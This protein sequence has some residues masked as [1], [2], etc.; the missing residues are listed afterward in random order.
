MTSYAV[1]DAG[2]LLDSSNSILPVDTQ[3]QESAPNQVEGMETDQPQHEP[4]LA[5][6]Q[7][8]AVEAVQSEA[9]LALLNENGLQPMQL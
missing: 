8:I 4:A 2:K 3:A 1:D 6:E 7:T 9:L 5:K